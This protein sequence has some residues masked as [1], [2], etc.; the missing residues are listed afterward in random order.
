MKNPYVKIENEIRRWLESKGYDVSYSFGVIGI[1]II[2]FQ[3]ISDVNLKEFND[4]FNCNLTLNE[5]TVNQF[6]KKFLYCCFPPRLKEF[7]SYVN[8]WLNYHKFP[9]NIGFY[10]ENISLKCYDELSGH[11]IKDFENE[12]EVRCSG[13]S[14]SCGRNEYKYVFQ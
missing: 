3:K 6:G 9:V 11:Q 10:S 13:Y 2:L 7:R 12:F 5:V 14:I 1:S 8:Q 4:E